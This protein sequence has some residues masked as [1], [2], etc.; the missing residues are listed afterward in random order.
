MTV[1]SE[2]T[3]NTVDSGDR[4]QPTPGRQV[5]G[6]DTADLAA[7]AARMTRAAAAITAK[8]D[9]ADAAVTALHENAGL[10]AATQISEQWSAAV[11]DT[12]RNTDALHALGETMGEAARVWDDTETSA[13]ALLSARTRPVGAATGPAAGTA[14]GTAAGEGNR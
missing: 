3:T 6:M 9:A 7:A 13:A 5:I 14:A 10:T 4:A 2:N 8:L 12:R 1:T 11:A